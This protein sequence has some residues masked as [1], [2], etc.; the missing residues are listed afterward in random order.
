MYQ[1]SHYV[2]PNSFN[3]C[4]F[5]SFVTDWMK[6]VSQSWMDAFVVRTSKLT[7]SKKKKTTQFERATQR[8]TVSAPP[9]SHTQAVLCLLFLLDKRGTVVSFI[10]EPQLQVDFYTRTNEDS[11]VTFH[12]QVYFGCCVV[13]NSHE[14]GAWKPEVKSKNM[15]FQ[16]G[17]EFD[18]SI[19]VLDSK[20]QVV[21]R[22]QCSYS[23]DHRN[24]PES[25]RMVQVWRDVSLTKMIACS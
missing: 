9:V 20:Y 10:S 15:P 24:L 16:D 19:L 11:D 7:R 21:V 2:K 18:L 13:M 4:H 12:F 6:M 14:K 1:T 3:Y 8:E 5:S 17:K 23:F 22:G 25:V